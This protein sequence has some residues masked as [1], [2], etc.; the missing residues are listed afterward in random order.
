MKNPSRTLKLLLPALS[1]AA[2]LAAVAPAPRAPAQSAPARSRSQ[3]DPAEAP[4]VADLK[5][6]DPLGVLL[7]AY[8]KRD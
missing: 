3:A 1:A 2:A 5:V 6:G 7:Y 8:R 4:R